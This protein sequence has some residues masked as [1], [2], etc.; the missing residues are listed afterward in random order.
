MTSLSGSGPGAAGAPSSPTPAKV[1]E[2]PPLLGC[3]SLWRGFLLRGPCVAAPSETGILPGDSA[4]RP[5]PAGYSLWDL[6]EL[7]SV[8]T[9]VFLSVKWG[10]WR[11]SPSDVGNAL[12][13]GGSV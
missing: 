4:S 13:V 7:A 9:S 10:P 11:P 1:P 3:G 5:C 12:A 6:E 2:E 8:W